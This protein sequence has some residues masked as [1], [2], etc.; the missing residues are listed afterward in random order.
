[1]NFK[2][3]NECYD[4]MINSRNCDRMRDSYDNYCLKNSNVITNI[5]PEFKGRVDYIFLSESQL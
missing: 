2:P 5:K 3:D 4:L 1:M